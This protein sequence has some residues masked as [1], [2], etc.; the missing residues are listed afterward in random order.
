MSFWPAD[1]VERGI[2]EARAAGARITPGPATGLLENI[3]VGY[4]AIRIADT[5]NAPARRRFE[6]YEPIV[7]ALNQEARWSERLT[8]PYHSE[9]YF[10][11]GGHSRIRSRNSWTAPGVTPAEQEDIIW[12]E[13]AAR[14]AL[15][16]GFLPDA[17]AS[18]AEFDAGVKAAALERLAATDKVRARA[19]TAGAIGYFIGG[20]G[21]AFTDP[22][23][24]LSLPIGA[25]AA[26]TIVQ[27]MAREAAV[28]MA[29]EAGSQ[30][31]IAQSY[32]SLGLDFTAAD[33]ATNIAAAGVGAGLIRGGIEVAPKAARAGRE[34]TRKLIDLAKKKPNPTVEEKAAITVLETKLDIDASSPFADV[35]RGNAEHRERLAQAVDDLEAGRPVDLPDIPEELYPEPLRR[36]SIDRLAAE[37]AARQAAEEEAF[38]A[39]NPPPTRRPPSLIDDLKKYLASQPKGA[40]R[41]IDLADAVSHGAV[42][43]DD[44]KSDVGLKMLFRK[45]RGMSLDSLG[46]WYREQGYD[47]AGGISETGRAEP[48]EIAAA[49]ARDIAGRKA[50]Q[51]VYAGH[52]QAEADAYQNWLRAVSDFE[53]RHVEKIETHAELRDRL[54][55]LS[56][57]EYDALER[58]AIQ[59]E[60]FY[61]TAKDTF[62]DD[63]PF[64]DS[65][66]FPGG[67]PAR[68]VRHSGEPPAGGGRAGGPQRLADPAR[69]GDEAQPTDGLGGGRDSAA[70]QE[71]LDGFSD[72]A[73][74]GQKTQADLLEHDI[75]ARLAQAAAPETP[76]ATLGAR[77]RQF[78]RDALAAKDRRL[79]LD[80]GPVTDAVA[81]SVAAETGVS[82]AGYRHLLDNY[83]VRHIQAQHGGASETLRGQLP[84]TAEDWAL[85]PE[86]VSAPDRVADAGKTRQGRAGVRFEKQIGDHYYLVEEIRTK[87]RQLVPVTFYKR[88]AGDGGPPRVDAP[89]APAP[90]VRDVLAGRAEQDIAPATENFN[91]AADEL[92]LTA[93]F[94]IRL[95]DEGEAVRLADALDELDMDEV[96]LKLMEGCL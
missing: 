17:P 40:R 51:G 70:A 12:R 1:S 85:L 9:R 96:A 20:V 16:P 15:D 7:A 66:A 62:D 42:H 87:R 45:E 90:N 56:D 68:E 46:E 32:E 53:Q 75:R 95:S 89:K 39:A 31:A 61:K 76:S 80:M 4:E 2:A 67:T 92:G 79:T 94:E 33:A 11:E 65:E 63:I 81:K 19:S 24:I 83:A 30:P 14:R 72:P 5:T 54:E 26:R 84:I 34:T 47:L 22:V 10:P 38:K 41:G 52:R 86:I 25:G 36:E 50:G 58:E 35:P 29:I 88:P 37:N 44:L 91:S 74:P 8:N 3:S 78:F 13:I 93:D 60:E 71:W 23:N 18:K 64:D 73:G 57:E 43:P 59:A 69:G 48:E 6:A 27:T 28:N 49:I 55:T 77:L 82:V 21:G